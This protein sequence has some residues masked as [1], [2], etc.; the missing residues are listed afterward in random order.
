MTQGL[1][2]SLEVYVSPTFS[3]DAMASFS[4]LLLHNQHPR[5]IPI[6]FEPAY[7][8]RRRDQCT[9]FNIRSLAVCAPRAAYD[10]SKLF[11][12]T[13]SVLCRWMARPDPQNSPLAEARYLSRIS[14]RIHKYKSD[15]N[16]IQVPSCNIQGG[17]DIV[18]KFV[19]NRLRTKQRNIFVKHISSQSK[20]I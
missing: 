15:T 18:H 3:H 19:D 9:L 2:D 8:F 4:R 1:K 10:T 5:Q 12:R 13:T 11:P 6:N 17:S 16:N 7:V 14:S 20:D